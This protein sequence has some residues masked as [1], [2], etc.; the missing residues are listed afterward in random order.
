MS[1]PVRLALVG[2]AVLA[3][4]L[5]V[6][7]VV[8]YQV[9]GVTGRNR[10]DRTLY[11]E[12]D[13]LTA[14][15][16]ALLDGQEAVTAADLRSAAQQYLALHP[17]SSGHLTVVSIGGDTYTS[18]RGPEP[19]RE[20]SADGKLPRG[21]AGRLTTE[22]TDEGR[23]RILNAPLS[24]GGEVVGTAVIAGSLEDFDSQAADT[25]V[26]IGVAG[27]VGLV[28][29][30]AALT[31]AS[32]RAVRPVVELAAAARDTGGG[33]LTAR[34]HEPSRMDEVGRLAHEF[35]RMLDRLS[36]DREHRR[37]V[38]AAVAHELRTPLAVARGHLEMFEALDTPDADDSAQARLAAVLRGELD[39]LARIA[40]DLEAVLQ[41]DDP[42]S[43]QLGPVFAPDVIGELRDRLDGLGIT[44]VELCSVPPVV[45]EADQHRLAQALLNLVTNAVTHT[46]CG[47]RVVVDAS[48]DGDELKIAVVDDGPGIDASIKERI[49]EPFVT[50]QA[51][52]STVGRGLGLAV[53][54][55]LVE[56]QRGTVEL[57][58]GPTGTQAIV[59]LPLA[60]FGEAR[61]V[62]Q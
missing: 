54:K 62:Q 59:R 18:R 3:A 33:E 25:L 51:D 26:G 1:L 45:I 15:L 6:V 10:V 61:Q 50:T 57:T 11:E 35:N 4:T 22:S 37:R 28:L 17:G 19:L 29:G 46:S 23:V 12:L 9:V 39:R 43:V 5:L 38:L 44:S 14:A 47:T 2:V 56:A 60:Q 41:G 16:P 31:V 36:A 21:T 55:S 52:G 30:G 20:L 42:T 7:T 24:A 53:V 13:T 40:E 49:F 27:L 58:T 32:H 48:A 8:T 34:V